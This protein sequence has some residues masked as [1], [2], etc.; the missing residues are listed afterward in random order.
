MNWLGS[1]FFKALIEWVWGKISALI[2]AYQKAKADHERAVNQAAKDSQAAKQAN[3]NPD[4]VTADETDRA[5][6][7][8][9]KNI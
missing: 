2:Q 3:Q 1:V 5:I 9:F 6:D 7:D 8:E 4:K